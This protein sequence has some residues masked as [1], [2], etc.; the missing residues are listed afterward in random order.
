MTPNPRG[1]FLPG[2]G[3]AALSLPSILL[4]RENQILEQIGARYFDFEEISLDPREAVLA[5][6][7]NLGG[8]N[9]TLGHRLPL[10]RTR[11]PESPLKGAGEIMRKLI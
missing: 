7:V 3:T 4:P 11:K 5:S 9:A 8:L 2:E 6:P 10:T 1:R